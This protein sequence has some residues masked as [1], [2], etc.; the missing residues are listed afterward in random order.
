MAS[1]ED[2]QRLDSSILAVLCKKVAED[3]A[4]E[5]EAAE[6]AWKL[7]REWALLM[8]RLTPQPIDYKVNDQ[9]REEE[10]KLVIRMADFLATVL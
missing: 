1:K 9:L 3:T 10:K 8:I 4:I 2:L 5:N 6:K 7:N